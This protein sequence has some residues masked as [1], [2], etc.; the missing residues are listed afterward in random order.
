MLYTNFQC[1]FLVKLGRFPCRSNTS[2]EAPAPCPP[3]SDANIPKGQGVRAPT[4][5]HPPWQVNPRRLGSS[6]P[7]PLPAPYS[8]GLASVAVSVNLAWRNQPR[9]STPSMIVAH[10]AH[11]H[12]QPG[13]CARG[14]WPELPPRDI[15]CRLLTL[16]ALPLCATPSSNNQRDAMLASNP[17]VPGTKYNA[18]IGKFFAPLTYPKSTRA[19]AYH[20]GSTAGLTGQPIVQLKSPCLQTSMVTKHGCTPSV[21]DCRPGCHPANRTVR[22]SVVGLIHTSIADTSLSVMASAQPILSS[23]SHLLK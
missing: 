4:L 12:R 7:W 8:Q 3:S 21:M 14:V 15:P 23:Q 1:P 18:Q 19:P 6:R 22:R 9:L 10:F 13:T 16:P 2:L 5:P 11:I 17:L 20:P